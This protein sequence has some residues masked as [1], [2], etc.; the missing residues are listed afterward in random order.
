MSIEFLKGIESDYEEIVDFANYVFSH[1]GGKTDFPSLL[2]KLY[3]REYNTMENHYIV[4]ENGK[5]KAIVGVF[6][7]DLMV[8]DKKL[9][10]GGIGTVSV[11]PYSR[12]AGYMKKL[13]NMAL[14]DMK[15]QGFHLSCLGGMKQR[16]EYFSY[17][18]CGQEVHFTINNENVKH[19]LNNYINDK[20]TFKEILENKM[21]FL[22]EAYE[23]YNN[24][25]YKFKREKSKFLDVLKSWSFNVYSIEN[26]NNFIGYMVVT[27]DKKYVSELVV[28]NDE[29]YLTVIANYINYNNLEEINFELPLWEKK[30]IRELFD[31]AEGSTINSSYQFN[32]VNY[33]ETLEALLNFKNSYSKLENGRIAIDINEYGK[34]EIVINNDSISV[35]NF[36]GKCDIELNHLKA[37]Q[38]LFSPFSSFILEDE[39]VNKVINSWFPI[40]LFISTQDKV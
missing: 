11:H 27:P 35:G 40:P 33:E 22:D 19:K 5:I 25:N 23:L 14:E 17:T 30:K 8:L 12:G 21:E 1:S 18:P 2:P 32:I 15:K 4:K 24:S 31:I 13:M 28:N 39:K 36:N 38:L 29:L 26:N 34:I 9:K 20:I 37:M 7:M 6:S 10:V 3:K 16:Y